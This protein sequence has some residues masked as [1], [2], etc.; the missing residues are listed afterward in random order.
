MK[1]FTA[2]RSIINGE[3]LLLNTLIQQRSLTDTGEQCFLK[4]KFNKPVSVK[5]MKI[6]NRNFKHISD[7]AFYNIYKQK[8]LLD[9][10]DSRIRF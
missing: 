7:K 1:S 10:T 6:M 2:E 3:T 9:L 8:N 4:L 5:G